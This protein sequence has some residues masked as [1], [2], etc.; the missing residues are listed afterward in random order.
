MR[1]LYQTHLLRC[2][3]AAEAW[4]RAAETARRAGN[5]T[6]AHS[7]SENAIRMRWLAEPDSDVEQLFNDSAVQEDASE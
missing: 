7:C 5:L 6:L 1:S 2:V 4:E 3:A